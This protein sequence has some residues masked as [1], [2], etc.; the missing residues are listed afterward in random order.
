[1]NQLFFFLLGPQR[2]TFLPFFFLH[3]IWDRSTILLEAGFFA[4]M[5]CF[6]AVWI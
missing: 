5:F 6:S 2:R 3:A 4:F 1:M